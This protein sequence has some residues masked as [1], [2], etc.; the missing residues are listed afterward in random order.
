MGKNLI[1]TVIGAVVILV[2]VGFLAFAY[3]SSSMKPVDGYTVLAKF[4]SASGL[5][6]GSD[7]RIGGIKVGVVSEMTLD[8]Q[9]YQAVIAMDIKE[10]T[11]IPADSTAS[12]V[13]DGLLGSKYVSIEPGGDEK[14]LADEDTLSFTQSSV[15]LETLIG[16]FMF[17]GGGVDKEQK[18]DMRP[19]EPQKPKDENS[20]VPSVE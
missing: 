19:S 1:E 20:V 10:A 2:A 11:K 12:I 4:D 14:T 3:Q 13:G 17:S 8:P 16:K 7:V 15:N 5:S 18:E 6:T 9:T